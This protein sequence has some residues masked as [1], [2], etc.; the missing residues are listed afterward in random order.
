MLPPPVPFLPAA[1][2]FDLFME[3]EAVRISL[4]P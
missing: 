3:P 4:N 1:S 2:T